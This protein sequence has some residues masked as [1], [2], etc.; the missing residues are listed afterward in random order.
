MKDERL[1]E[2]LRN[3][4]DAELDWGFKNQTRMRNGSNKILSYIRREQKR[5]QRA[6]KLLEN[7]L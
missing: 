6:V 5:R 2:Q 4:T 3:L 1:A 7:S